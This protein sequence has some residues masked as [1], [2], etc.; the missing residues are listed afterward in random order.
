VQY[1]LL[2]AAMPDAPAV[3]SEVEDTPP[4]AWIDE[5][6]R[7]GVP[8]TAHRLRKAEEPG[9][10]ATVRVRD[11]QTLITH[12]PYAEIWEQIAGYELLVAADLDD[13]IEIAALHPCAFLGG[14]EIRPLRVRAD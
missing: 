5:M 6:T 8:R 12:G 10:S 3:T 2:M 13:A 9:T 14:V 1:V 7:R 4:N 11:G